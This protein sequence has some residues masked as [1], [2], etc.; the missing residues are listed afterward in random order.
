MSLERRQDHDYLCKLRRLDFIQ[1][2]GQDAI[3][4]LT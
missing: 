2:A 3:I 4:D 1:K